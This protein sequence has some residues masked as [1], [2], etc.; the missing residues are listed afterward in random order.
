MLIYFIL[1]LLLSF[2]CGEY[3]EVHYYDVSKYK[4]SQYRNTY[5]VGLHYLDFIDHI[6]HQS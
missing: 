4:Y 3:I 5:K 2:Q 1:N 6:I